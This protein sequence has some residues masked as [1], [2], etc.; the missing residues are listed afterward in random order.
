MPAPKGNRF[1]EAR[2]SHGRKP[3]FAS[4]DELWEACQEYFKWV[5][6]NPLYETKAFCNQGVVTYAQIPK[7]RAMTL[8]GLCIFLDIDAETWRNY[9]KREDFF[10]ITTRVE[11]V[12]RDQKFAGAS[13]ELLNANIIARDLGLADNHKHAGDPD[14]PVNIAITRRVVDPA[15]DGPAN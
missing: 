4:P 15:K 2:S 3:I 9:A 7:M 11:K 14:N 1:W 13:A 10:G 8:D 5:E 6:D 12:I